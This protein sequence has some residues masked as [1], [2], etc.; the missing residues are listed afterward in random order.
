MEW[1]ASLSASEL[2]RYNIRIDQLP[3]FCHLNKFMYQLAASVRP[4]KL[5]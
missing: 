2:E 5:P 1:E 3:I 4:A